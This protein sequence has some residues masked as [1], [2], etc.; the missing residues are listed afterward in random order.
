MFLTEELPSQS[1]CY[2]AHAIVVMTE[3]SLDL[4]GDLEVDLQGIFCG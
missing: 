1:C 4:T 3:E 2:S